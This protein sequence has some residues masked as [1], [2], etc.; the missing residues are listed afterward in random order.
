M[1]IPS[2]DLVEAKEFK[3]IRLVPGDTYPD[4]DWFAVHCPSGAAL[5][6]VGWALGRLGESYG[7]NQV[8]RDWNRPL[9]GAELLRR[10]R[11][12]PV[13]CSG[14]VAYSYLKAGV[15]L[16]RRPFPSPADLA[17]SVALSKL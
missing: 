1:L 9:V 13:D 7:W 3:G 10:S 14:L 2:G 16:T 12:Q 11:L 5:R 8:A 17:W 4:G 6:A 15:T